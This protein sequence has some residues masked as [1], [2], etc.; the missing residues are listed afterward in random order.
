MWQGGLVVLLLGAVAQAQQTKSGEVRSDRPLSLTSMS[1]DKPVVHEKT[2]VTTTTTTTKDEGWEIDGPVFLRSADPEPP[3]ELIIKN[4]FE[5]ET[6]K[7]S[8]D[9][10]GSDFFY[11]FEVEYGLV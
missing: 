8:D 9:D 7:H 3:G 11:E 1:Q 10:D 6:L 2:T 5:W 4:I